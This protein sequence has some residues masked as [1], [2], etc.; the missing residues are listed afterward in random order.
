MK[1]IKATI[2]NESY[3]TIIT[4]G[5]NTVIS[6]ESAPHGNDEGPSPYDYLLS[7]LGGCVAMTL[8]MYA[9]RK[10]WDLQEVEV[11][12]S[13]KKVNHKD[14]DECESTEGIVHLIE[15]KVKLIGNLDDVQRTRLMEIADKC[16]VHKT[17]LNEIKISTIEA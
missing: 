3:K 17:L 14:C 7:A 6:D 12:L 11:Q 5:I 10:K 1:S 4:N 15:K 9:G 16:P 13:Q 8:R 2:G